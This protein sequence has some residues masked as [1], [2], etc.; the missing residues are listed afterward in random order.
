MQ[1]GLVG[2]EMCIRDRVSTQ[3][4]W[5]QRM[6]EVCCNGKSE[7]DWDLKMNDE[8]PKAF[9]NSRNS[10]EL[11]KLFL[12]YRDGVEF[13]I[14]GVKQKLHELP[15]F[16]FEHREDISTLDVVERNDNQEG[17]IYIGFWNPILNTREYKGIILSS[18]GSY[19][20]GHFIQGRI[21][22]KGRKIFPQLDVYEGDFCDG[23][24]EGKGK[25]THPNGRTYQ[26]CWK[27]NMQDGEG[28]EFLP[29]EYSY[30]GQF[31]NGM[32]HLY[33]KCEWNDGAVYEG[34]FF[35]GRIE[36][37]GKYSNKKGKIYKGEWQG[38]REHGQGRLVFPS[39]E[40][41]EGQFSQGKPNGHG[42]LI[43]SD[44]LQTQEGTWVNSK[45]KGEFIL[46]K[47][48]APTQRL[49]MREGTLVEILPAEVS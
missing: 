40:V 34:Q 2:S 32:K 47:N 13:T 10:E 8:R 27:D 45:K 36:G 44:G 15:P 49:L 39:G 11:E 41:Y 23:K 5:E 20:E 6:G 1:R 48:N 14:E 46:T 21:Q 29:G 25:Y 16:E 7:N 17:E 31:K 12:S 19:F 26:G 33:G 35:E 43:S 4:T 3:S 28:K 22:G 18:D 38:G 42:K 24:A 30:E 9:K 37:Q